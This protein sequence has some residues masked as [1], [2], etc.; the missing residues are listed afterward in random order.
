M[1]DFLTEFWAFLRHRKKLWLAPIIV[2]MALLGGVII[3]A[4][5][6]VLAPLLYTIF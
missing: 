1:K 6:S 3:L 2:V 4:K 5:G